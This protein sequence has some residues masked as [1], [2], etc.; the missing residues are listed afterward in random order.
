MEI[1]YGNDAKASV[2]RIGNVHIASGEKGAAIDGDNE[3]IIKSFMFICESMA[4]I[5]VPEQMLHDILTEMYKKMKNKPKVQVCPRCEN[6][7]IGQNDNF[8]KI[9]GYKLRG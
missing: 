1:K 2:Q 4:I 6:I 8:C 7:E 3:Q 5:D 9:C